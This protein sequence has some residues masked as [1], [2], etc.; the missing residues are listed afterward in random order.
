MHYALHLVASTH[1]YQSS[2]NQPQP[3]HRHHTLERSLAV[4]AIAGII[5][6]ALVSCI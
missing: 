3:D 4:G 5:K 1:C 6:V 2:A